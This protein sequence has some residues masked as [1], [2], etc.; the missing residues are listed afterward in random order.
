MWCLQLVCSTLKVP[1][2]LSNHCAVWNSTH[3]FRSER[4]PE[5]SGI[6]VTPGQ[7]SPR[8]QGQVSDLIFHRPKLASDAD[9]YESDVVMAYPPSPAPGQF[10]SRTDTS[11][12]AISFG[13]LDVGKT[14]L[15]ERI[16]RLERELRRVRRSR[17]G[18]EEEKM[19]GVSYAV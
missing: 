3:R 4:T 1:S 12:P 8:G 11:T 5:S 19:S 14:V 6:P 7:R 10:A 18:Q 15:L 16:D 13:A 17:S 9:D 2:I